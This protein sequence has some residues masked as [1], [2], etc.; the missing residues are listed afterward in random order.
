MALIPT[1]FLLQQGLS[2]GLSLVK[3][4]VWKRKFAIDDLGDEPVGTSSRGTPV[5]DRLIIDGSSIGLGQDIQI[6]AYTI[7]VSQQK[8]L[9]ETAL[10]GRNGTT[11]EYVST[12]DY[13]I[14][15]GLTLF[16]DA[17]NKY[18][19]EELRLLKE[20]L[21]YNGNIKLYAKWLSRLDITECFVKSHSL[22][23]EVYTQQSIKI[24]LVSDTPS[25]VEFIDL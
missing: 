22:R 18:P 15:I 25:E 2:T 4:L 13:Q 12:G 14:T 6:D 16:S 3:R 24:E 20:I 11:K 17:V 10:V 5:Y 23:A 8:N 21:N 7:D 19:E 9:V 1:N